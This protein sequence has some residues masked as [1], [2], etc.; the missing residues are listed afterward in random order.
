MAAQMQL[1]GVYASLDLDQSFAIMRPLVAK[2]NE[3]IAAAAVLDGYENRYLKEGEWMTP[4]SSNLSN[5]L[6]NLDQTLANLARLDFDRAR[7]LADQLERPEVRMMAQLQIV[8]QTINNNVANLPI[9]NSRHFMEHRLTT[10]VLAACL[11][12]HRSLLPKPSP[13]TKGFTCN[14]CD[15]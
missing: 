8:Q 9:M 1:A 5:L 2:A 7:S 6:G 15:S 3:L 10:T 4:G 14:C 12:P 11:P 13:L